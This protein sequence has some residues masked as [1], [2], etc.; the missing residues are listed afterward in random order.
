MRRLPLLVALALPPSTTLAQPSAPSTDAWC[1]PQVQ[2]LD[3]NVCFY[4]HPPAEGAPSRPRTLV[5]FLHGLVKRGAGWQHTQQRSMIRHGKRLGFSALM[6]AGRAGLSTRWGDDMVGWP[7]GVKAQKAHE[8]AML[9]E[10]QRARAALTQRGEHFDEVFV[11]GF[12]N[13][14]YYASS[15]ALR[16]TLP[17]D[18]Y[19]VFAGGSPRTAVATTRVPMFVG[20]TAKDSTAR[21]SRRLAREL[22]R[23]GWPHRSESRRVGHTVSDRHLDHALAYLRKKA[24]RKRHAAA[25]PNRETK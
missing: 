8:S 12:S 25:N 3:D 21:D 6:P 9:G 1:A 11:V 7:T 10:W 14:A 22:R 17:V 18:G 19:A 20:I 15:L 2:A 4:R 5:I 24:A 23:L 16:G 13:G